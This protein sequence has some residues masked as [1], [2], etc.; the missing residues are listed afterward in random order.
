MDLKPL[1]NDIYEESH[2]S[3]R[4]PNFQRDVAF[5]HEALTANGDP[6][7]SLPGAN[8]TKAPPEEPQME[9]K[10][11]RSLLPPPTLHVGTVVP[12][13]ELVVFS[14]CTIVKSQ[15]RLPK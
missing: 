13:C 9:D 14:V 1:V 7:G 2:V 8:L 6:G 4:A 5:E 11:L 15:D 12:G 3:L 10:S